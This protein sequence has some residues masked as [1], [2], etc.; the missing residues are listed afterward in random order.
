MQVLAKP[1]IW[2][3]WEHKLPWS[4][5]TFTRQTNQL[6]VASG[7]VHFSSPIIYYPCS[8]KEARDWR[9]NETMYSDVSAQRPAQRCTA[10][11]VIVPS[12]FFSGSL[13]QHGSSSE[14]LLPGMFNFPLLSPVLF[15]ILPQNGIFNI[16]T[17]SDFQ[18][19]IS[20]VLL[21]VQ[22]TYIYQIEAL[23]ESHLLLVGTDSGKL[24][25]HFLFWGSHPQ[26]IL[27]IIPRRFLLRPQ[28]LENEKNKGSL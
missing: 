1:L 14:E 11:L 2:V 8:C 10:D 7:L 19:A 28:Q 6:E 4:K 15:T 3:R 21:I 23:F 5:W 17:T 18:D 9:T 26:Q 27:V 24:N 25:Y 16:K 22:K 12:T 13:L 20:H